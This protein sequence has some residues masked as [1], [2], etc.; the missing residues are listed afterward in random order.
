MSPK[1]VKKAKGRLESIITHICFTDMAL[2]TT[3]LIKLVY[4]V[5]V[6]HKVLFGRRVTKVPFIHYHYG[7]WALEIDRAVNKLSERGII[8]EKTVRTTKGHE[9]TTYKPAVNKASIRLPKTAFEVLGYVLKDWKDSSTDKIVRYAK[10]TLP[11]LGT[12]MYHKVRFSRINPI[13][14]YAKLKHIRRKKVAMLDI[15]KD[16]TLVENIKAGSR[17]LRTGK[18]LSRS[19]VFSE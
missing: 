7:P 10:T 13:I 2:S 12:Q 16:K 6:Y 11:F 9:A 5:D 18:L 3:K 15:I 17:D 4:L 1:K 19:Q 8:S 14:Q